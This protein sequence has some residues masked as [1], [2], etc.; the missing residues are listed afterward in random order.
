MAAD[1]GCAACGARRIGYTCVNSVCPLFDLPLRHRC[2]A[3]QEDVEGN[4]FFRGACAVVATLIVAMFALGLGNLVF[5][6][7]AGLLCVAAYLVIRANIPAGGER[8]CCPHCGGEVR[9]YE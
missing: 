8:F 9:R 1:D 4:R 2:A 3:W 7:I 5:A 6:S